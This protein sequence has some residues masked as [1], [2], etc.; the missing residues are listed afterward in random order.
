MLRGYAEPAHARLLARR[1]A[2]D[3]GE[4]LTR[5][6]RS[7]LRHRSLTGLAF[8]GTALV[9]WAWLADRPDLAAAVLDDWAPH[10]ARP[11]AEPVTAELRR[12]AGLAGL[13]VTAED[14][15]PLADPYERAIAIAVSGAVASGAGAAGSAADAL[16]VLADLDVPAAVAALRRRLRALGVRTIPRGPHGSTRAHPA[17]LTAR[18]ADVL[19]LVADGLTNA[20]IAA[21]LV[22]SVRTVDHHVSSILGKLGVSSRREAGRLARSLASA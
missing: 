15:G 22:V 18:Q 11:G 6:W 1:G 3:V 17:G 19:D 4:Q 14:P 7:A 10:A 16:R 8:A 13:P 21:R 2:A 9:E 5:A 12:Y 20:E